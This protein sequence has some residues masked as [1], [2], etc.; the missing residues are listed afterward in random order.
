[1]TSSTRNDAGNA[2]RAVRSPATT[3]PAD[4]GEPT[5]G[6]LLTAL[7]QTGELAS[8]LGVLAG[9]PMDPDLRGQAKTD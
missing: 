6:Q 3:S 8:D 5:E 2:C 7:S 1:M 9:I 4:I